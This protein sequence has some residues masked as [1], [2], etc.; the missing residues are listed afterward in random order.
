MTIYVKTE[1][2]NIPLSNVRAWAD[3]VFDGSAAG[4]AMAKK[5]LEELKRKFVAGETVQATT[6]DP[7][8][9]MSATTSSRFL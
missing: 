5:D 1:Y 2:K 9:G 7:H 6:C 4:K 8:S 3:R